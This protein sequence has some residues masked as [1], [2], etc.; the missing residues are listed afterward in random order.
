MTHKT[1]QIGLGSVLLI[2]V[3]EKL[4]L[5]HLTGPFNSANDGKIIGMF[6]GLSFVL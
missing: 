3:L 5:F 2:S 4:S 6:L 1:L